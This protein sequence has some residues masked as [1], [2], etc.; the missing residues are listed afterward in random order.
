LLCILKKEILDGG[1]LCSKEILS[2]NNEPQS[3]FSITYSIPILNLFEALDLTQLE[4]D[5]RPN[6]PVSRS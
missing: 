6:R 1:A 2:D 5:P 4:Y 3:E